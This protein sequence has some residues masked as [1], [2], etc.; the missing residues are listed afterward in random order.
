MWPLVR[1]SHATVAPRPSLSQRNLSYELSL[2]LSSSASITC[3]P[4]QY[5]MAGGMPRMLSA[6]RR[7]QPRW[8]PCPAQL[9]RTS[10]RHCPKICSPSSTSPALTLSGG[11]NRIV[12]R[13]PASAQEGGKGRFR[14]W[15][16]IWVGHA[17]GHTERQ[18]GPSRRQPHPRPSAAG[19]AAPPR[20]SA[21]RPRRPAPPATGCRLPAGSQARRRASGRGPAH[22]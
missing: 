9:P 3:I 18:R 1:C 8:L 13:A 19:R 7:R 6:S 12:S 14:L 16:C 10:S 11:R 2:L 17:G 20:A 5:N 15:L 21:L 22:Q 4:L